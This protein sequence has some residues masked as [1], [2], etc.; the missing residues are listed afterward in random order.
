MI[1][2]KH[3]TDRLGTGRK[4]VLVHGNADMD[5]LGSAY[6]IRCTFPDTDIYAPAGLDRVAKM[7]SEKM[8]IPVLDDAD[9]STYDYVVVVDTSS[10]DLLQKEG[11]S[12]PPGSLIID[13]HADTGKWTTMDFHHDDTR[14]S[15][16]EIIYELITGA[17]LGLSRAAGLALLGGMLTDGGH[18]QFADVRCLRDFAEIMEKCDIPMD[19]AMLLVR[20]P[21]NMSEKQAALKAVGRSRFERVGD[22]I[23]AVS[24]STSF[25]SA[26]CRALLASGADVAFVGSQREDQFRVS[27][28]A[29]QE[30]VR[31]GL[32]LD[33]LMGELSGETF[34]DGGGHGGAAGMTGTGDAEAMCFMCLQKTMEQFRRIKARMESEQ[35]Q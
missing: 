19:E 32:K 2:S 8:D 12:I 23:V 24:F 31:R 7:V 13:H 34:T 35:K 10:P 30:M 22:M 33:A 21:M 26:A 25:E 5:A 29:T 14:T 3:I 18:F 9:L 1:D 11:L 15:C 20:A 17:G 28:R 4:V 6:A 27:G 16:C